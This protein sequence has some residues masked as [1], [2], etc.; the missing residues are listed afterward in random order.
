MHT[1]FIGPSKN[2]PMGTSCIIPF[3]L[4]VDQAEHNLD[5]I[6]TEQGLADVRGHSPR[7]RA[8]VIIKCNWWGQWAEDTR[9]ETCK[10]GVRVKIVKH[11]FPS[12]DVV[13]NNVLDL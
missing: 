10:M 2:N 11:C 7:E 1:P 3:A 6:V 12:F 8:K 13:F 4:H 5:V 9:T